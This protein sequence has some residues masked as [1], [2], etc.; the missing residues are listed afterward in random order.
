MINDHIAFLHG[1]DMLQHFTDFTFEQK[2]AYIDRHE[3]ELQTGL[4][5]PKHRKRYGLT[6]DAEAKDHNS[7]RLRLQGITLSYDLYESQ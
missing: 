2:M 7:V 6:K 4:P 5:K 3:V 1:K